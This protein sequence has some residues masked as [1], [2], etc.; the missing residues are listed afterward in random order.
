M[1]TEMG[2]IAIMF[3]TVRDQMKLYHWQTHSYARHKASDKFV[4]RLTEKIDAFMEEIQG[5]RGM[6][7]TLPEKTRKIELE[8]MTNGEAVSFLQNFSKWLQ[9]KLPKLLKKSD[10]DL[11][12]LRDEILGLTNN[13]LYLF[14]L[15]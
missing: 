9:D 1:A 7:L 3:L 5:S 2:K 15:K 6:R 14:T 10:S 8:N 11:L 13:T 12:N 4:S